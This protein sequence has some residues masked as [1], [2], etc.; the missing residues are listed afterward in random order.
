MFPGMGHCGGGPGPDT[1]DPLEPLVKWVERH[2][3]GLRSRSIGTDDRIDNERRAAPTR[4]SRATWAPAG[5]ANYPA[6]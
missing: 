2:R 6:N 5:G 3:T 1:W 4:K